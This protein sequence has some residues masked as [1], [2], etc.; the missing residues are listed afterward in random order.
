MKGYFSFPALAVLVILVYG[1]YH[2]AADENY[3]PASGVA[4]D[5]WYSQSCRD[6][7]ADKP[8]VV[9]TDIYLAA[10][11]DRGCCILKTPEVKCVY[12]NKAFCTRKAKQA[13]AEF[14]FQNGVEC[15]TIA[16]CR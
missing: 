7:L 15:K 14:E 8:A 6:A 5:S 4:I 13:N 16:A 11:S 10:D 3:R 12:T 2:A 1:S 9:S